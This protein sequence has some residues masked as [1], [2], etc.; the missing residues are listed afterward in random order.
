MPRLALFLFGSPSIEYAG[1]RLIVDTR[2]AIA[3]LVYLAMTRQRYQRDML[4]NLLWPEYDQAHARATLRRTLS[5]LNKALNG[6]FLQVDRDTIA[7]DP[8]AQIW[9]DVEAFRAHLATCRTHAHSTS[10][11]CAACLEPLT[12]AAALYQDDFLAGFHLQDSTNFD[13][14]Q[15]V[16]TDSLRREYAYVLEHL[17]YYYSNQGDFKQAITLAQRWLAL[18]HLHEPA[19]SILMQLYAGIG[20]RASSLQQYEECVRILKQELG[21]APLKTTTQI[22]QAIKAN[23]LPQHLAFKPSALPLPL[24][25]ETRAAQEQSRQASSVSSDKD[26]GAIPPIVH[27]GTYPLIGRDTEWQRMLQVYHRSEIQGQVICLEGEMGIGKTRL[28][29]EMLSYARQRGAFIVRTNCFAE[30]Q[31]IAYSPIASSVQTALTQAQHNDT[32]KHLA[33]PWLREAA[34][35]LPALTNA[36][37]VTLP[38]ETIDHP[39]AQ[40]RFFAGI[41]QVLLAINAQSEVT[42]PGII[43]FDD[44]HW[45]DAYSLAFLS[46]FIRRHI[47]KSVCLLITWRTPY[48]HQLEPIRHI[49]TE[50][51][52]AGQATLLTLSRLQEKTVS[53]LLHQTIRQVSTR[54]QTQLAQR[55]YAESEGLPLFVTAYLEALGAQ[56]L[57]RED[58]SWPLPAKLHDRLLSQLSSLGDYT[59]LVLSGAASIGRSFDLAQL[60]AA[61]GWS[62]EIIVHTLEELIGQGFLEELVPDD[63]DN[64]QRVRYQFVH[65]QVRRLAYATTSQAR[66]QLF[67][68]RNADFQKSQR[69]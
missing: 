59:R 46:Y 45:S 61:G 42:A 23:T 6:E 60:R 51:Q 26:A 66:R 19:H 32:L 9:I 34:R 1:K 41:R 67:Q 3:L 8:L 50:L 69:S 13:S 15:F 14:W 38:L 68:Q 5:T 62:D 37:V 25:R 31:S 33:L 58:S 16:Q 18:D 10:E 24:T 53:Q 64:D 56:H 17:V 52:H 65:K 29:E 55:L 27:T 4:A 30:E 57:K 36:A 44:L 7:L 35:L 21:I 20:Q 63:Q 54:D 49:L 2:K 43:C 11:T 40:Q 39:E 12:R 48:P 22:Y 28:L 47:E